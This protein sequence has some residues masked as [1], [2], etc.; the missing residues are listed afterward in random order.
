MSKHTEG[1]WTVDETKALGAYGVWTDYATHPGHDGAGYGSQICSVMPT[2]KQEEITREQR[3]ANARLIAA[4][5]ELLAACVAVLA[6]ADRECMPQGGKNDGPWEMVE[7][8]VKQARG[9]Q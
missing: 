1:P 8:A 5:P 7:N 9:E 6:W 4:S 2:T 3:D